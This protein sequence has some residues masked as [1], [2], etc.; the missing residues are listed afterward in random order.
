MRSQTRTIGWLVAAV[1]AQPA[2]A[3]LDKG[4]AAVQSAQWDKAY[5]QFQAS[6]AQGNTD[7]QV[8]LGNLYLRGLG[9]ERDESKAYEWYAKAARQGNAQALGK[10]GILHFYGLGVTEDHAAAAEWF[11]KAAEKGNADAA[12]ILAELH[13]RGD[14]VRMSKPSAYLWYSIAADL[15]KT[16][17]LEPRTQLASEL[18]PSEVNA[19][20]TQ[21]NVWRQE[22]ESLATKSGRGPAPHRNAYPFPDK[23]GRSNSKQRQ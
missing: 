21:L 10:L 19:M 9:V 16:E 3:D 23:A 8:N 2:S 12:I 22:H 1:L 4:L 15:G 11:R 5:R 18:A 17:A 13:A 6:A 7:A 14:G 20:L